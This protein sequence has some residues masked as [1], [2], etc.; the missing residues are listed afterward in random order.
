MI[1]RHG[2]DCEVASLQIKLQIG[3]K[4]NL[5][6][7]AC[8]LVLSVYPVGGDLIAHMLQH[9]RDCAMLDTCVY[10]MVKYRFDLRRLCRCGDIPVLR[11]PAKET[12]T[13]ASTYRICLKAMLVERVY[14]EVDI[15]R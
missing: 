9:D 12:V 13:H 11:C 3:G 4:G 15:L 1:I 7:M 6:W 10:R 8:I 2:I 14:Y 5:L